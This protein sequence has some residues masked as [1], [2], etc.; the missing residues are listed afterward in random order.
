MEKHDNRVEW[1]PDVEMYGGSCDL[2]HF[3]LYKDDG[4][5]YTLQELDD[6]NTQLTLVIRDAKCQTQGLRP[7]NLLV[8][9]HGT[10]AADDDEESAVA[11]FAFTA[12][13]T[14]G[15]GGQYIYQLEIARGETK[16]PGQGNLKVFRNIGQ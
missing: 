3:P 12:S 8:V 4:S 6:G 11:V 7:E 13:D 15:A 16:K 14:V 10:L 9:K 1:L 2:W 5:R